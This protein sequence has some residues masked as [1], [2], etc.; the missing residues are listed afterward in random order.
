MSDTMK[1]VLLNPFGTEHFDFQWNK[2]FGISVNL[3]NPSLGWI[4]EIWNSLKGFPIG[5]ENQILDSKERT[6]NLQN[7]YL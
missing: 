3:S 6:L 1:Y 4:Q 2:K 7:H 5:T